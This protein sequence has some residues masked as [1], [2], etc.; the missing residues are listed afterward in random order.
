[1][2][3]QIFLIIQIKHLKTAGITCG[4]YFTDD[5]CTVPVD[6]TSGCGTFLARY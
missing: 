4:N 5:D 6:D 1:M 3:V 2:K